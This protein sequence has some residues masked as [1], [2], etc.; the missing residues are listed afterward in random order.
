MGET[1]KLIE[2]T[3]LLSTHNRFQQYWNGSGTVKLVPSSK[4][5]SHPLEPLIARKI[6]TYISKFQS[7][8]LLSLQS[9]L[10]RS[11]AFAAGQTL[12]RSMNNRLA[13]AAGPINPGSGANGKPANLVA[14]CHAGQAQVRGVRWAIRRLH[15]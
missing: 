2:L 6:K 9:S 4:S 15:G 12:Y 10:R 3:P 14:R 5:V 8:T 11:R 1:V 7:S 13:S